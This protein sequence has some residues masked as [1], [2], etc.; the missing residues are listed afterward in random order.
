M[1]PL[2]VYV[3]LV[4]R[5]DK[6]CCFG[7]PSIFLFFKTTLYCNTF[8]CKYIRM[9][10]KCLLNR[11][12]VVSIY[13]LNI[14]AANSR[15]AAKKYISKETYLFLNLTLCGYFFKKIY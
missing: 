9:T 13:T 12:L 3:A 14:N 6:G 11:L 8:F 4:P 15:I 10:S 2:L 7:K 1:I 5:G